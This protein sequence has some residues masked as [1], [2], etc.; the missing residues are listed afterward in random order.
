MGAIKD[1][2]ERDA[3]WAA[4][5]AEQ[6][7]DEGSAWRGIVDHVG[8]LVVTKG[9]FEET[10][11]IYPAGDG[12]GEGFSVVRFED[13]LAVLDPDIDP[14]MDYVWDGHLIADG[15]GEV[16]AAFEAM[17]E[18]MRNPYDPHARP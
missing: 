11:A 14:G 16:R 18:D 17:L 6:K 10:Y 2:F 5:D 13:P 8:R 7:R 15:V 4:F 9:R 3:A 12:E 1:F